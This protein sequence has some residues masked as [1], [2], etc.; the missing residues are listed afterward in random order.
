[1][2]LK[3]SA[4]VMLCM[5]SINSFAG[6]FTDKLSICLVNKTTD[7][8]KELLIKWIYA[9]MSTHPSVQKLNKIPVSVSDNLNRK[10]AKLFTDLLT[11]RC[12][13]E[14]T[15][16]VKYEKNIAIQTSFGVLGKVAMQGI[17]SHPNVNT[18]LS[19][20]GKYSD[21]EKLKSIFPKQATPAK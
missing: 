14:A 1:M 3:L 17:M 2:K 5:I 8:D 21:K 4:I 9:A 7:A 10:A 18:Y 11:N 15:E 16:A 12:K 6:P 20:L 19:Q 13:P